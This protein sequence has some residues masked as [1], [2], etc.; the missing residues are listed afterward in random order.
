METHRNG[1]ANGARPRREFN[2]KLWSGKL[3]GRLEAG[4][5]IVTFAGVIAIMIIL[6]QMPG[7]LVV[8]VQDD[9]HEALMGAKVRCTSPDGTQSFAGQTDVF[10]EAKWPGLAKGAWRCQVEAPPRFHAE[11]QTGFA[12]VVSRS[13]AFWSTVVERPARVELGAPRPAGS[14]RAPIAARA[15]CDGGESWETRLGLLNNQATLYVPH[16]KRCRIGLVHPELSAE[17]GAGPVAQPTLDCAAFPCSEP[18]EGGVG[19]TLEVTLKATPQ[20][21]EALRPPPVPDAP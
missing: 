12:T 4:V 9:A 5:V 20:Q 14:P 8:H 15:L 10:G 7:P 13:P 1:V 17:V 6:I 19:Q 18:V 11:P 16:G 3:A 21:W 2:L